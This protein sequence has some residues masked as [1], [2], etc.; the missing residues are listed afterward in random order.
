[1]FSENKFNRFLD[2]TNF[3]KSHFYLLIKKRKYS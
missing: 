3:K 1:M 2:L